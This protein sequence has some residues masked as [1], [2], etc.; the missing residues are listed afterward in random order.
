MRRP[1]EV[2]PCREQ[3]FLYNGLHVH[4]YLSY[5]YVC[6]CIYTQLLIVMLLSCLFTSDGHAVG[7][8]IYC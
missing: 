4:T 5:I 1:W 8:L 7:W 6:V 2:E 3:C